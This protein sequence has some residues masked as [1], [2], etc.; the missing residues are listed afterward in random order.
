[1]CG[2]RTLGAQCSRQVVGHEHSPQLAEAE[3]AG[4]AAQRRAVQHNARARDGGHSGRGVGGHGAQ[5]A[6]KD[7]GPPQLKR[8]ARGGERTAQHGGHAGALQAGYGLDQPLGD[9]SVPEAR[10]QRATRCQEVSGA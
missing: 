1:M 8:Q 6:R 10:L 5:D 2:S 4:G 7:C 9:L 3:G